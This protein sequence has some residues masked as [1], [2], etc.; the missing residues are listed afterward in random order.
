MWLVAHEKQNI[1][2]TTQFNILAVELKNNLSDSLTSSHLY[3]FTVF[4][5]SCFLNKLVRKGTK[6][7]AEAVE[8]VDNLQCF[9]I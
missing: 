6:K 4:Q 8:D 9:F 1:K 7:T 2:Y 3:Y 5:N